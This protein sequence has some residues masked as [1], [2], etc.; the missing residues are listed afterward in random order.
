V[1]IKSFDTAIYELFNGMS[2][3][4][5]F[6]SLPGTGA[7]LAPMLLVAM[8]ENRDR[9]ESAA[10]VQ[11]YSGIALVTE[12]SGKKSWV[13]WRW[14][15]SKFLRQSFIEWSEKSVSQ[16]LWASLYYNQLR[17]I[18]KSHNAAVRALAFKW[19]R[20]LY[21]CWKSNNPYCETK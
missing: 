4:Y 12:R 20:I 19:I 21:K 13:H 3:A 5:I 11:T 15:C 14:Q 10:E 2:D 8:G 16:S 7:F 9:F 17:A 18:G 1:A 6:K